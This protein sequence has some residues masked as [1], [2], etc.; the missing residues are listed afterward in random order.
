MRG[1]RARGGLRQ[2]AACDRLPP[3]YP[4]GSVGTPWRACE[5]ALHHG[6]EVFEL[7]GV[8][9]WIEAGLVVAFAEMGAGFELGVVAETLALIAVAAEV[10][11]EVVALK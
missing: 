9:V 7:Q 2:R 8:V 4:I 10:V 5:D 3:V 1:G 11:P 6:L